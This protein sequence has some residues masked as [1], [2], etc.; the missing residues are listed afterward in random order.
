[1]SISIQGIPVPKEVEA[2][3]TEAVDDY[4]RSELNRQENPK[5][6]RKKRAATDTE[7]ETDE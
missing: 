6:R 4:V 3:G 7:E 1:M 5:P 2:K